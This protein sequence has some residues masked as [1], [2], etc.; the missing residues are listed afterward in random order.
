M[1]AQEVQITFSLAVREAQRRRHEYLTT[2]HVLYAM[3][4][5]QHGKDLIAACGGD[6]EALKVQLERYFAEHLESLV[7]DADAVPEQTVGLQRV[8]QRAVLHLHSAGKKE[9]TIGDLLAAMF[10]EKH[11]HA[12]HFLEA[13]G[14]SRL[15]VLNYISHG[16]TRVPPRHDAPSAGDPIPSDSGSR[17]KSDEARDKPKQDPLAL[18]TVDL[19]A[20]ARQGRIDPLIGREAELKRTVQVL[21]RRRKNNPLFVGEAGV[22]KTAMAE[23]L[24]LMISQQTVPEILRQCSVFALD[25]GALLAGTKFRGDF[26]ERLKAV[27]KA[28]EKHPD[29]ILFIDEIHTVVGAGA[30]SGGSLDASNILKP[31]LASGDFRC[32]GSTTYEEYK[33]LFD[34]DR[35]LSRRFQKIDIVEPSVE[36]TIGILHG[37]KDRYEEHHGVT[38][39]EDA[40]QAAA[41]LSARHIN[42]RH[43]PDKAIDVID[44]AGAA[45]RL[46]GGRVVHL[47]DIERV[48]A[49]IARIPERSVSTSDRR[50]LKTL[51]RDLSRKVFGQDEAVET[52][53]RAVLRARAGLGHPEKPTGSFLFTGPTGVGKTEAARQ[54]ASQLGVAFIRFDMSEYME[55][56]SVSRLIGA[57]PG[58]VGFDQGG[59]LT[60]AVIKQP[61]AVLLLD[62]IEKAHPDLF[63]ILL[64]VMDHGSLTD[65]NGKK[66]DFR[67][68][69]LIMTSNAGAREMS[70]NPIGFGKEEGGSPRQAV[71]RTFSPEFRNRLDAIIPFHGLG[72]DTM[73]K[74]V[75]KFIEELR[76]RLTE[77]R[78]KLALSPAARSDLARRGYDPR[79]GARPLARLIQA[80][81]GDTIAQEILFGEL[82]DG[83]EVRIGC[84]SGKLT[85]HFSKG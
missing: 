62:E 39:T 74:I 12:V 65:N 28:L 61:Y 85:Y 83:G 26:E 24:A 33:N 53:S 21:C 71:E 29:A 35:A 15:D 17:E 31:V 37:L 10:A 14:V 51:A 3:L 64:Q 36:E 25:M 11:T 80:E 67:N 16:V 58:Y 46:A 30:T 4:L 48:V 45:M 42:F 81:I 75:D 32:I 9:I 13:Q 68:V 55:K 38:Y 7:D 5:E 22:G 78:V 63:S 43:L 57:P 40:I 59:L 56:H 44:E 54:L 27:V 52:L 34:K 23:G 47:D 49:G 19:V 6:T 18:F 84:R 70:A 73:L 72:E 60:E 79:F 82:Q 2:E 41:E 1:F 66:A 20:R 76:S 8:L 69:V 77:R 50:R